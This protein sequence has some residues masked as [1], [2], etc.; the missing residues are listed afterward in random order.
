MTAMPSSSLPALADD[1]VHVWVA[2][3]S[4]PVE[5]SDH[6]VLSADERE[7]AR[8]FR[9]DR[10]RRCFT[11]TR[12]LARY[13]V[14]GYLGDVDPAAIVFGCGERG[15]PGLDGPD[16]SRAL[17]FNWSHSG[18]RA[19]IAI[20]RAGMVGVDIEWVGRAVEHELLAPRVFS[21]RELAIFRAQTDALRR[22]AFFNGW[23][24]KEAFIKATGEGMWQSLRDFDVELA[25]RAPVR[26]L[27]VEGSAAEAA[28]WTLLAFEPAPN[29][30]GAVAVRAPG[31]RMQHF[32]WPGAVRLG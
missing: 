24:R 30:L 19:A 12:S 23:T 32:D 16:R 8:R 7:R 10:D 31:I 22:T 11:H 15:K 21:S 4:G 13:L 26:V 14:A 18:E 27:A 29:Y 6:A 1:A 25:P 17:F 2:D 3:A 20:T 9:F 5:H 28:R